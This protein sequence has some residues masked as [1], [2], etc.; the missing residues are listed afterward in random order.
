MIPKG[1]MIHSPK[2]SRILITEKIQGQLV[3]WEE[4]FLANRNAIHLE[5]V[6][7]EQLQGVTPI[8]PKALERVLKNNLPALASFQNRVVSLPA[9]RQNPETPVTP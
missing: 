3:E 2:N 7:A 8:D 9:P 6:N 5:P 1:A 4:F